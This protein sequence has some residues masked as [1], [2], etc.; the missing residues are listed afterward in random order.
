MK[1][2]PTGRPTTGLGTLIESMG[3]E[4][5]VTQ[6]ATFTKGTGNG[7]CKMGKGVVWKNENKYE[8][9]WKNGVIS[10]RGVFL[11]ANGNRYSGEWENGKGLRWT[12]LEGTLCLVFI[13]VFSFFFHLV[14]IHKLIFYF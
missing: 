6:T 12:E 5:S 2:D 3:T 4:R 9:E 7:M 1:S 10:G 8:G 13:F 14:K 11:W